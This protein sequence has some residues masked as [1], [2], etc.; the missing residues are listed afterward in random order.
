MSCY[1][2]QYWKDRLIN[3]ETGETI[4]DGTRFTARRMNHIEEGIKNMCETVM[5]M[6]NRILHLHAK[7]TTG[8]RTAGN[9][10]IFVD[11]FD[12]IQD[13]IISLD[14]TKAT[15]QS[16]SGANV[17]VSS[18]KGFAVGQEITLAS[19]SSQEIRTITSINE[20]T[21]V[22]TLN[23]VPSSTYSAGSLLARSTVEVD[24]TAKRMRRGT[25]DSYSVRIS[26]T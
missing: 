19:A 13:A 6:E 16:V 20:T 2:R 4:Q 9:N 7:V 17:T 18:V 1:E 12:G 21:R 24:T 3:T 26:V 10:G 5:R 25:I 14:T 11:T 23:S 22:I 15:I 8:D